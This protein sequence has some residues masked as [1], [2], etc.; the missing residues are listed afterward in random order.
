MNRKETAWRK[1]EIAKYLL[2]G[3]KLSEIGRVLKIDRQ[4]VYYYRQLIKKEK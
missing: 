1:A 3:L 4:L 2:Q